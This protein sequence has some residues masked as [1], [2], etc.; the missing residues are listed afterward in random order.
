[1]ANSFYRFFLGFKIMASSRSNGKQGLPFQFL[2]STMKRFQFSYP[3]RIESP[4]VCRMVLFQ[5]GY[6]QGSLYSR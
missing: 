2:A 5:S 3:Q 1:M 4:N 6:F